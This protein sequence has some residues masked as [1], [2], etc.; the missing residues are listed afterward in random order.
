MFCLPDFLSACLSV[1]LTVSTW[2]SLIVSTCA[3]LSIYLSFLCFNNNNNN[4]VFLKRIASFHCMTITQAISLEIK[5][6]NKTETTGEHRQEVWLVLR[7]ACTRAQSD[8][9]VEQKHI[10]WDVVAFVRRETTVAFYLTN[11]YRWR[12]LV[13]ICSNIGWWN[14]TRKSIGLNFKDLR[15]RMVLLKRGMG[16]EV[17]VKVLPMDCEYRRSLTLKC[18]I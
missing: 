13:R 9:F 16:N 2:V 1:W 8:W 12:A 17:K 4:L 5:M 3:C 18:L 11:D 10:K 7:T 15:K 6:A 14:K